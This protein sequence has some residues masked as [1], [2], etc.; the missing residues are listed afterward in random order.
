MIACPCQSKLFSNSA[1]GD[2]L[3][4]KNA[5][6]ILYLNTAKKESGLRIVTFSWKNNAIFLTLP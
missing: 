3:D 5:P 4:L 2:F 1:D 6:N